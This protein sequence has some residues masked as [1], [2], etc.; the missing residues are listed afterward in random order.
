MAQISILYR[1]TTS[2][3]PV[4][5]LDEEGNCEH[6][7]TAPN[8]TDFYNSANEYCFTDYYVACEYCGEVMDTDEEDYDY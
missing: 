7:S 1:D 6:V 8:S 2:S 5:V 3:I 4:G